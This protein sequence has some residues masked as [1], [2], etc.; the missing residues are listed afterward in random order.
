MVNSK[1]AESFDKFEIEI[2][3]KKTQWRTFSCFIVVKTFGMIF[4]TPKICRSIHEG[5]PSEYQKFWFEQLIIISLKDSHGSPLCLRST[6]FLYWSSSW[7]VTASKGFFAYGVLY[8]I[9]LCWNPRCI[10]PLLAAPTSTTCSPVPLIVASWLEKYER[11]KSFS[12]VTENL[13]QILVK[14]RL[15]NFKWVLMEKV[16]SR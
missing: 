10:I 6:S 3:I 2:C 8:T 1:I 14:R 15:I 11:W 12:D 7:S 13:K 5:W 9:A 4:E 16:F